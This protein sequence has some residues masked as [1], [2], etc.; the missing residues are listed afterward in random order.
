MPKKFVTLSFWLSPLHLAVYCALLFST[1]YSLK[2]TDSAVQS[3]DILTHFDRQLVD[4]AMKSRGVQPT[5]DKLALVV[6]DAKSIKQLGRWPWSRSVMAQAVDILNNYYHVSII[7]FDIVFSEP[8]QTYIKLE[9]TLNSLAPEIQ[10]KTVQQ[11]LKRENADE[12]LSNEMNKWNNVVTGYFFR[13]DL[14]E[15]NL[16]LNQVDP[17]KRSIAPMQI[18]QFIGPDP[19]IYL[20]YVYS[21]DF[22]EV[23]TIFR[24]E[25]NNHLKSGFFFHY[26][27]P[28]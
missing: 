25:G 6:V 5:S 9:D 15:S 26:S 1:C 21:A 27:R 4:F 10:P 8:D 7:G 14:V 20:R 28:E 19:N 3:T 17:F 2:R 18:K 22:P 24:N 16:T 13:N 12:M 23:N 11:I